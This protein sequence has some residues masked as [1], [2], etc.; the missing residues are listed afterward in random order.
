MVQV[1]IACDKTRWSGRWVVTLGLLVVMGLAAGC[2]GRQGAEQAAETAAGQPE[3]LPPAAFTSVMGLVMPP[4]EAK[5][6]NAQNIRAQ[7][8]AIKQL[9]IDV[10]GQSFSDRSTPA[11]WQAY[12]DAAEAEGL[13]VLPV[14]FDAPPAWDGNTWDLGVNGEFLAAMKDHPALYA[15]FIIDEPFHREK[16]RGVTTAALRQLYDQVKSIAPNV[17]VAVQFSREIT[18]AEQENDRRHA[19]KS[20]LC[21]ICIISALEFRNYG[22]GNRLDEDTLVENQSVSRMVISREAPQA[23][24]WTTAQVFGAAR[25]TSSGGSGSSYFMPSAEQLQQMV[26]LLLSAEV[27]SH[28]RLSGIVWQQWA[29]LAAGQL[30]LADSPFE[31]LR[32]VVRATNESLRP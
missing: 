23:Q 15:I 2:G 12:L 1:R 16:H 27:Q 18:D 25:T 22:L 9:G 6:A 4:E 19:F 14:F 32:G 20:G 11:D 26:D 17:P 29:H 31:T 13:G 5:A 24:I 28:G 10:A 30:T 8:Q 7:F 21:D 3:S